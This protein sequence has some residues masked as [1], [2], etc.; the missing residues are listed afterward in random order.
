MPDVLT[1]YILTDRQV[2]WCRENIKSFSEAW[3]NVQKADEHR[4]EVY[5]KLGVKPGAVPTHSP[6]A[7]RH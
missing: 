6:L 3:R 4:L 7:E 1:H 5:K 2:A